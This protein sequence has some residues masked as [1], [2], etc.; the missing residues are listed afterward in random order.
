MKIL[1]PLWRS[2]ISGASQLNEVYASRKRHL[3][4]KAWRKKKGAVEI[5]LPECR[6]KVNMS[7]MKEDDDDEDDDEDEDPEVMIARRD[8]SSGS[9]SMIQEFMILAGEVAGKLGTSRHIIRCHDITLFCVPGVRHSLA[10]PY[11]SQARA[12]LPKPTE[13]NKLPMGP[14]RA[15][16]LRSRMTRGTTSS[17]Q[18]DPH[19]SLGMRSLR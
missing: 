10:L 1:S 4:R 8:H 18:A 5:D 3:C 13:L 11:R 17:T 14:C 12:I 16:A 2:A 19:A 6:V 7:K 15:A 9:R